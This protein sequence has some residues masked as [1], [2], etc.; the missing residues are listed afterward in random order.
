M[1]YSQEL[2]G[3]SSMLG[4]TDAPNTAAAALIAVIG[5]WVDA[6]TTQAQ[7]VATAASARSRRPIVAVATS[8]ARRR[9]IEVAGV[10]EVVRETP[11][12]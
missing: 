8:T 2:G 9:G 6:G 4:A 10:E 7:E 5:T 3:D 11:K 12:L 1:A